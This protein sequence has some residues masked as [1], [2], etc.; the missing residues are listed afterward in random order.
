MC[1]HYCQYPNVVFIEKFLRLTVRTKK[2]AK[3]WLPMPKSHK[4]TIWTCKSIPFA[5]AGAFLIATACCC[6][7]EAGKPREIPYRA[8]AGYEPHQV[9]QSPFQVFAGGTA[10]LSAENQS[11]RTTDLNPMTDGHFYFL[12]NDVGSVHEN[13]NLELTVIVD[14]PLS[15]SHVAA[16]SISVPVIGGPTALGPFTTGGHGEGYQDLVVCGRR[17]G[18]G[19]VSDGENHDLDEVLLLDREHPDGVG[20]V[21]RRKIPLNV[22]RKYQLRLDRKSDSSDDD[23]VTLT[24]GAPGVEPISALLKD[25][26]AQTKGFHRGLIFGH[27]IGGGI[28]EANWKEVI[29][30]TT[31]A[32]SKPTA[33]APAESIPR[34]IGNRKQLFIDDWLIEDRQSLEREQGRPVK[35]ASNPV[36]KREKPWEAARCE[37]YGSAIWNDDL[38]R[39]ELFYSAM[40]KHYDTKLALAVSSDNGQSWSRPNLDVFPWEAKPTNIVFPGRYWVHGPCVLRDSHETDPAKRYKMFVTSAPVDLA[41]LN[42]EGPRG[43]DALF[44]PDGVHWTPAADNPVIPEFNSDT[45][46]SVFWDAQRQV[47][48]AYVRLR[49]SDSFRTVGLTES[50]DFLNWSEP[51]TV[52]VPTPDDRKR[53]WHFYGLSVTP[54]EGIYVGLVWIFPNTPSSG[55]NNA[56][57]PVTW[58]ELVISRDG[59]HWQRPFFGQAFLPLGPKGSFDHRQIRTASSIVELPDQLV[60]MY[61]GSP[62]AHVSGH[63]WDIGMATL[64]PDGFA[65]LR[66]DDSEGTLVTKP[67]TFDAG[68]LSINANVAEGGYVKAELLD[69][70]GKVV[71]G[72]TMDD[73]Q[74]ITGDQVRATLKWKEHATLPPSTSEGMRLRFILR[75]AQLYSF[76]IGE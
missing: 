46:N 71:P 9:P 42:T 7:A 17:I 41:K 3:K 32:A 66:A 63:R 13:E 65:A 69:A 45:G 64:R 37:L 6:G 52:Y 14:V 5:V 62:D 43:I 15:K 67:M 60:L 49:Q 57:A 35:S 16:T 70:A 31:T 54:Y 1:G 25:F 10:T 50:P 48:R 21:G 4:D 34:A 59:I 75:R 56:D 19:F 18:I 2:P 47:Y 23:L 11:L 40:P 76:Q 61:S 24:I 68:K 33:A 29:F 28:A 53:N 12:P 36:L 27:E 74:P 22:S 55:D 26:S 30:Q 58:P 20:V 38:K 39:L 73:C 44:S 51:R 8:S 72:Y